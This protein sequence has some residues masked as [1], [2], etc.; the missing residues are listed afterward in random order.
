[1]WTKQ[2]IRKYVSQDDIRDEP[3]V[4]SHA[5]LP[6]SWGAWSTLVST[7]ASSIYDSRVRVAMR[8]HKA[9]I[10]ACRWEF[11]AACRMH[12]QSIRQHFLY[13]SLLLYGAWMATICRQSGSF[14]Q[15]ANNGANRWC[16]CEVAWQAEQQIATIKSDWLSRAQRTC[17]VVLCCV[18]ACM[19]VVSFCRSIMQ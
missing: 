7:D 3:L 16:A 19:R 10:N 4:R 8:T 15:L 11:I 1:M 5:M 2:M 12:G 14:V 6:W 9:I 17:S 18:C 13:V